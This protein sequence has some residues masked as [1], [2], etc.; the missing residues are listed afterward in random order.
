MKTVVLAVAIEAA[1]V[2][3]FQGSDSVPGFESLPVGET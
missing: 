2:N 3:V 1:F